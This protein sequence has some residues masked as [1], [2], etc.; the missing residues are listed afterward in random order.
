MKEKKG[1][2]LWIEFLTFNTVIS[3]PSKLYNSSIMEP[4]IFK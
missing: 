3:E 2:S 1:V 4:H